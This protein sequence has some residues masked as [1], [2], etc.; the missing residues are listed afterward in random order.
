MFVEIGEEGVAVKIK[1]LDSYKGVMRMYPHPRSEKALDGLAAYRG[2]QAGCDYAEAFE[3][4]F[5]SM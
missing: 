4:V 3:C 1:A 2:V 5:R